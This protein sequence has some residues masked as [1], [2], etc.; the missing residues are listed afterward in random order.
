MPLEHS[1]LLGFFIFERLLVAVDLRTLASE[2]VYCLQIGELRDAKSV[3]WI[4][5]SKEAAYR[6]SMTELVVD[7]EDGGDYDH[8][9]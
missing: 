6:C 4:E 3:V 1:V 7:K 2:E 8:G 5:T 9:I